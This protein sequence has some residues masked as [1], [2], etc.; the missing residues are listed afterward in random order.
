MKMFPMFIDEFEALSYAAR[1][2]GCVQMI[3]AVFARIEGQGRDP[4]SGEDEFLRDA[5]SAGADAN[6]ALAADRAARACTATASR[7]RPDWLSQTVPCRC[8]KRGKTRGPSGSNQADETAPATASAIAIEITGTRRMGVL[9][10]NVPRSCC[11]RALTCDAHRG[12]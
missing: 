3:D 8:A 5:I 10:R 6:V 2:Q 4:G 9:C 11:T 7:S 1:Q 12:R